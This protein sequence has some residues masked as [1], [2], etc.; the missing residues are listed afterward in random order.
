M[1]EC[2]VVLFTQPH[3]AVRFAWHWHFIVTSHTVTACPL[4]TLTPST[5]HHMVVLLLVY[6]IKLKWA[7]I[8]VLVS[9]KYWVGVVLFV[10]IDNL[11]VGRSTGAVCIVWFH[12]CI[13]YWVVQLSLNCWEL[14]SLRSIVPALNSQVFILI[15]RTE[16]GQ[17]TWTKISWRLNK[18]IQ[19]L[20][21]KQTLMKQQHTQWNTYAQ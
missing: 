8:C 9:L 6:R 18:L 5:L 13:I 11:F 15:I 10:T 16:S 12:A 3:L 2:G 4:H 17:Y 7:T 20:F 14:L 19:Q 1:L 21:Y